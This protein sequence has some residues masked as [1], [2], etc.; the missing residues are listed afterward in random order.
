MVLKSESCLFSFSFVYHLSLCIDKPEAFTTEW[1]LAHSFLEL[2]IN[3]LTHNIK[4]RKE[5]THKKRSGFEES[6]VTPLFPVQL[7][8][9]ILL[10]PRCISC[11]H[12][13]AFAALRLSVATS[14]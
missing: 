4:A 11:V 5:Q 6:D 10:L 1:D 13:C 12:V 8:S 9:S 7:H 2:V 3:Q 14:W